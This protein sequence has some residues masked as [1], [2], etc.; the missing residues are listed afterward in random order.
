[1][2]TVLK[3]GAAGALALAGIAA[4]AS[5]ASPTGS[6]SDAV[7]FAEVVNAAGSAVADYAGDTGVSINSLLAGNVSTTT[8]GS[9]ANLAKLFAAD[10]AG[11]GDTIYWGVQAGQNTN[12][13]NNTGT[14]L[15]TTASSATTKLKSIANSTLGSW[16]TGFAADVSQINTNSGGANSIEGTNPL[17]AG[18]WDPTNSS[19]TSNWYG[20][21]ASYNTVLGTNESLFSEIAN[22]NGTAAKGTEALLENVSLT[23]AGLQFSGSSGT[24]PTVPL[25]AAVWLLGSGLLGLTGVARRKAKA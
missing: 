7:L 10:T 21:V 13:S 12:G 23:S 1:M 25:P 4:H 11:S 8:L 22:S 17:A 9:D 2:N 19:N 24:S 20:T 15:T 16:A 5:I 18:I 3:V 14:F 6:S